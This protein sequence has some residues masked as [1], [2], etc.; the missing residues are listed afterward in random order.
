MLKEHLPSA[1][2]WHSAVANAAKKGWDGRVSDEGGWWVDGEGQKVVDGREMLVRVRDV[3]G[4]M[5]GKGRGK[6]V[7]RVEASLLGEEE[8][9]ERRKGKG[10]GREKGVL[11]RT[12]GEAV[13]VE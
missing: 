1:W 12:A 10:K 13:E 5:D 7:L 6:G 9:G 8:E 4:R 2:T 3:D 11:K